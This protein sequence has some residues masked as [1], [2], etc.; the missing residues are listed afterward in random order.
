MSLAEKIERH[1]HTLGNEATAAQSR[2]FFKTGPGQYGEGDLFIGIRVPDL[3]KLTKEYADLP[4]EQ[5][6][7]LL[8]SPIHEARLL[9]LL[10]MVLQTKH[11]GAEIY[12]A[13]LNNTHRINNCVS[14]EM[15]VVCFVS[16]SSSGS[17]ISQVGFLLTSLP[18]PAN[19][20]GYE[21][22]TTS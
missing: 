16:S 12:R 22:K 11:N 20:A 14:A 18:F 3:R 4:L 19:S 8:Q 1:L 21:N 9:A 13:Y 15:K 10:I 2:K 5:A 6:L 7:E 17:F